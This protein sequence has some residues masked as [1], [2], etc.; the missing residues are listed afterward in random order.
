MHKV[1]ARAVS[2]Q[3]AAEGT[4]TGDAG[5]EDG[6][7]EGL[8]GDAGGDAGAGEGSTGDAGGGASAGEGST[9]DAGGD[10]GAGESSTGDASGEDDAGEGSTDDAGGDA[11]AGEDLTGD[12]GGLFLPR[13]MQVRSLSQKGRWRAGIQFGPRFAPLDLADLTE[14]QIGLICSDDQLVVKIDE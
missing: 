8:T 4:K 9:D 11:G 13:T 7:G 5:G 3:L 10:A 6:A 2:M 1:K 14:D 12:K